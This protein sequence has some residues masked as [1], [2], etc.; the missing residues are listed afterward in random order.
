MRW[1]EKR[2]LWELRTGG[3]RPVDLR[4]PRARR[5]AGRPT[6]KVVHLRAA[7]GLRRALHVGGRSW[8]G[9]GELDP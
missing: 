6:A 9:A 4:G 3:P 7:R 8:L 5:L 2:E 1:S